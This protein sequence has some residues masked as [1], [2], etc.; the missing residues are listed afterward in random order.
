MELRIE[1]LSKRYPNGTE[2]LK[3]VSL[4]GC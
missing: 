1:G 3:N 2:A 4:A